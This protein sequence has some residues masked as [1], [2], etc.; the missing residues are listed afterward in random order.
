MS[1]LREPRF[2]RL[3]VGWSLS[4]FGD[5]ALFLT[6]AIWAKDLTGSNGAAGLVFLAL[7]A[8][9]FMSP[10]GGHLAD[11]VRRR[12]L[13][14]VTNLTGGG[15]VLAL[16]AVSSA[17]E[18]WLI[19]AVAFGLGV[20]GT[21]TG[22]AQSGL[23][24]DMLPDADLATANAALSTIDQGLRILSPLVGAGIYAAYG[25]GALSL[26]TAA[27][28]LSA[29]VALLS[30]RVAESDPDEH[31]RESFRREFTAGFR[32]IRANPLLLQLVIAVV[33]AFA[34]LGTYDSIVFAV[35]DE[36]LGREPAFFGVLM[37]LQGGG[38][39]LGGLTAVLLIRR[40]GEARTVGVALMTFAVSSVG[41]AATSLGVVAPAAVLGGAAI[42]WLIVGFV[43]ARQRHTPARL[44]GRVAAATVL[45]MNGPQT[46]SIAAGAILIGVVDYRLLI[47]SHRRRHR[48]QRV[49]AVA[50]PGP[51]SAR[52]RPDRARVWES[53][54]RLMR[55]TFYCES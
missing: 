25:G 11:R 1:A 17:A 46:L 13:L 45:A 51:G 27:T 35:V 19:Y 29:T 37:S 52:G 44:Q 21:V 43:T 14:I 54:V 36:G 18:L 8:P 49:V 28:F 3:L 34:V 16:L 48:G 33:I 2:R 31:P 5:S 20:V 41:F 53:R 30:V 22:S 47:A 50:P 24:K 12:P 6:L 32:H 38:S 7:A 10:L 39:I 15:M 23:L 26:L 40:L 4:N 9:V 42:P 55:I